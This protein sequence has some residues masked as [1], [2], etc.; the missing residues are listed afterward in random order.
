MKK[1]YISILAIITIF[2]VSCDKVDNPIE[3]LSA[4][5]GNDTST[6][7]KRRILIEEFTGQLCTFCPDGAREIE[8]LAGVYGDQLIPVSIHAGSFAEPGNGAPN[9]F[10]TAAG[11]DLYTTFGVSSNPAAAVSRINN[12]AITGKAQWE[13]DIITIKDNAPVADITITNTYNSTTR[14]VDIKVDTEWLVD[15]DA[16]ANYK[17]SV[18]IVEDHITAYQ[19]DNGTGVNNYD[20]RHVM[21]GAVNT[22]WGS[23]IAV[24]TS[25]TTDTQ[26]FNFTPDN[27]WVDTN[28][29]I[30]AFV[31]KEGPDYEVMQANIESVIPH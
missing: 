30:I 23:A 24:T 2:S 19:L 21:R 26:N 15:G 3:D 11:D 9:D 17:L 10:T 12:A 31:Y 14:E 1:I 27:A 5:G 28:C 16:G 22:T 13:A 25:G 7:L 4:G 29:E 6:V 20:H 18:Y 8:R